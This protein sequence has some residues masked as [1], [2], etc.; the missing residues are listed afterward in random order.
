LLLANLSIHHGQISPAKGR[1]IQALSNMR[2]LHLTCQQMA[3]DGSTVPDT[4]LG[5]PGSYATSGQWL[6]KMVPEYLSTNDLCK[7]LSVR[8]LT[9]P[10]SKLPKMNET[11]LRVY[12]VTEDS[13]GNT[14][15]F[16]S[17]NFT[18]T[19]T[20]GDALDVASKPF[21]TNGFVVFRKGGNG[22]V[23]RQKDVGKTNI[24][25]AFVPMC[26]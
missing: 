22:E 5:W 9:V 2:Q 20:G 4:N 8:E 11:A 16:T 15:L 1:M 13:P 23:L 24:I 18:N 10:P 26:R 25:G 19:P 7:L 21:G 3:L 6:A 12:A 14:V 17:S